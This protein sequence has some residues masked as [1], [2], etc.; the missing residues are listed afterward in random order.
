MPPRRV[1]MVDVV[2]NG[3]RTEHGARSDV[4]YISGCA[5]V[6][7]DL[8][9]IVCQNLA[10]TGRGILDP[11]A[12]AAGIDHGAVCDFRVLRAVIPDSRLNAPGC[13]HSGTVYRAV[14]DLDRG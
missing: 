2:G 4:D 5:G 10:V 6:V 11:H 7:V 13:S 3:G 1:C 9:E 14:C 12:V 8:G